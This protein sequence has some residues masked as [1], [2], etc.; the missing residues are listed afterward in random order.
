MDTK[1]KAIDDAVTAYHKAE[2]AMSKALSYYREAIIA[3]CQYPVDSVIEF[4]HPA[5]WR[6][7]SKETVITYKVVGH[8]VPSYAV[9]RDFKPILIVVQKLKS[10]KW[11][12]A[13]HELH[14]FQYGQIKMAEEAAA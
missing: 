8:S 2:A 14:G 3:N 5:T 7:G 6:R 13:T 4:T 11:G 9:R 10:G 12:E 1:L